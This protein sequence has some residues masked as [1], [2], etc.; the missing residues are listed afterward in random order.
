MLQRAE[1][2]RAFLR[3]SRRVIAQ[4]VKSQMKSHM[5]HLLPYI[6]DA[7]DADYRGIKLDELTRGRTVERGKH[8][9]HH[10]ACIT[11]FSIV[12]LYPPGEAVGQIN[13]IRPDG[14]RGYHAYPRA[15]KKAGKRVLIHHIPIYGE[16]DEYHPCTE[17]WDP[18]LQKAPF[19]VSL[20]AHTHRFASYKTGEVGNPFPVVVGGG[21]Q[22]DAATVMV[23]ERHGKTMTLTVYDTQGNEKLQLDL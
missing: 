9:L 12:H 19:A 16:R 14:R 10:S 17:L 21:F 8:I 3:L 4:D 6:P 1:G 18:L 22:P 11:S 7:Y 15:F 20:N 5:F 23:L 13:M 2:F